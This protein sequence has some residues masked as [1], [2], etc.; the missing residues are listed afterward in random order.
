M[1]PDEHPV[2]AIDL[3]VWPRC[4]A[5]AG[6]ERGSSYHP[7][8]HAAGR[9][10][11]AGRAYQG[12]AQLNGRPDSRTTPLDVRRLHPRQNATTVAAAQ[13]KDL[14]GRLAP[15]GASPRIVF[16]AGDDSVPVPHGRAHRPVAVPVRLRAG[17][18]VSAAPPPAVSSPPGGRPRLHGAKFTG[19]D[20][21]TWPA[22]SA[23]HL[24]A[25]KQD[26]TVR[27]R[28]RTG[29]HPK[30]HA[31]PGRGT[32]TTRPVVRGTVVLVAVSR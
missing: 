3:S 17:R 23:E 29:L 28:A 9:P 20:P 4:D 24:A 27:V 11:G 2:S 16:D 18:C 1:A 8:R 22:P 10:I 31:R 14:L 12:L 19:A 25:D 7:S 5:E 26:G 30:H 13:I 32:R 6:P 15:G 21:A